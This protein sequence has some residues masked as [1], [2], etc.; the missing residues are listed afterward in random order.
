LKPGGRFFIC[1]LHPVRQYQG[2]KAKFRAG[3]E[4]TEIDAF[5]H[6]ISDFISAGMQSGFALNSFDEWWHQEDQNEVPRLVSFM[7]GKTS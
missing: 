2:A 7:F 3:R 5:V 1:E 4:T 6:H